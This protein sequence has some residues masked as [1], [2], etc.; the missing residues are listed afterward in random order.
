MEGTQVP[1]ATPNSNVN[2]NCAL[3]NRTNKKSSL[4]W[5]APGAWVYGVF[6]AFK[7]ALC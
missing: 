3:V 4:D 5:T 6:W 1:L 7:A 2:V